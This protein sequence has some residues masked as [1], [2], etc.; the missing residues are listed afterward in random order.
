[1]FFFVVGKY[2]P[3]SN[4]KWSLFAHDISRVQFP[5]P[6]SVWL[7]STVN[8]QKLTPLQCCLVDQLSIEWY[9]NLLKQKASV[10]IVRS[11]SVN[12]DV[13]TWNHLGWVSEAVSM[14]VVR[15]TGESEIL[16]SR[17]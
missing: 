4:I 17:S 9:T 1:M 8:P 5:A 6:P 11:R 2:H 16:T 13:A 10:S 3:P 14:T 12:H 7:Y 15:T